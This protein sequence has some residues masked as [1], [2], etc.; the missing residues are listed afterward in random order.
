MND[1]GLKTQDEILAGVPEGLEPLLLGQ[2]ARRAAADDPGAVILHVARDDRRLEA[3]EAGLEFFAPDLK[4][5]PFPAWDTV[6]YDRVGPNAEIVARRITSLARLVIGAR[7]EPAIVLTTVNAIL[8]RLPPRETLRRHLRPLAAGQRVDRAHLIER[9]AAAGFVRTETVMEPGEFAVRGGIVDIFPPG[10]LNPV[11]LDFFGDT[12]ESI[13][14]FDAETQRTS[15]VV[16][17][18]VL[19]P[20]SEATIGEG[21]ASTF[22][23]RYIELF[24]GNTAD[25]PLYQAVI[26]GQHY[27][28]QE[29]WLPLFHH[30]LETLFDY[31]QPAA[32]SFEH[33]ADEAIRQRFD[34][35]KEHYEAR[36]ESREVSKFGAPP[37]K[38]V[39]PDMMF[40]TGKDW[41]ASIS[42]L[43]VRR[44]SPFAEDRP[45]VTMIGATAGRNFAARAPGRAG[46][47]VP[48]RRRPHPHSDRQEE[49]RD[50]RRLDARRTRAPGEPVVRQRLERHPQGR[51]LYRGPGAPRR[52]AGAG[53][54]RARARLRDHRP[55]VIG[56]Q[57]VLGDRLV[58]PRR[59]PRRAA[60]VITEATSLSVGD[61]VVHADHGIGRFVGLKTITALGAPHDCLELEYH[62]GDKLYLPV[63]NIELLT[64]YGSEAEHT[65]LDRLGGA[66]GSRARP[67]SSSGCARSQPS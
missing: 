59:K 41:G 53:C 36:V 23:T 48:R 9:L 39:P 8:Q 40:L 22:R 6:P 44:F 43:P 28:G 29:H 7:K 46:Q 16:Q 26:E 55:R 11:R 14:S 37:Y 60:D 17:K 18:L 50:R 30:Q 31:V 5:I 52:R 33:M 63:E 15:K 21:G 58:R 65:Q 27:P 1:V 56:E 10:R 2:I 13:K 32:V 57:D 45:G 67:A 19:M 35:I 62:G 54:A 64:R 3:L 38:P 51:E 61:L 25:D 20:I 24:G 66:P 47:F 34:A 49:A 42:G 4:V 12:L